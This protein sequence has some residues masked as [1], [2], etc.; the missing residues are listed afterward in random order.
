MLT[1]LASLILQRGFNEEKMPILLRAI[2][3]LYFWEI[4]QMLNNLLKAKQ[5]KTLAFEGWK[6]C[7]KKEKIGDISWGEWGGIQNLLV[8]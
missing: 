6:T 3:V 1:S 7:F 2:S 8:T 4:T 5:E